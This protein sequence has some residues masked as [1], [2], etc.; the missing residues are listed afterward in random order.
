M[1][2]ELELAGQIVG[3]QPVNKIGTGTLTISNGN[4]VASGNNNTYSGGTNIL[5]GTVQVSASTGSP[6]GTGAVNVNPGTICAWRAS[7]A[8]RPTTPARASWR[9]T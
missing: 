4:T 1:A 5:F 9:S 2:G 8:S 7:T 3:S 6:L